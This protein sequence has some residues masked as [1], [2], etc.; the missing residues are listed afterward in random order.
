MTPPLPRFASASC[1][2]EFSN[3]AGRRCAAAWHGGSSSARI[4]L[5]ARHGV[6][7]RPVAPWDWRKAALNRPLPL[8][9]V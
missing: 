9:P 2:R 4:C 8:W 5:A 3:G 1:G 7:L 6:W